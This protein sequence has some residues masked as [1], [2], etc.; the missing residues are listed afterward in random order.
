MFV[1]YPPIRTLAA[2]Q[3]RAAVDGGINRNLLPDGV[4]GADSSVYG[5]AH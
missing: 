2:A 5:G 4:V 3:K 1:S